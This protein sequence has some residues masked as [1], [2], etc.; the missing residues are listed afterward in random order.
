L[1]EADD[2]GEKAGGVPVDTDV[3][4]LGLGSLL[5]LGINGIVGVG[6]FFAPKELAA[7]APGWGSVAV[8]A[9]TG[10]ALLPVAL[11][12]SKLGSRFDQDG[13]PVLYAR[14]AFGDAAGFIVGWLA[15]VSA[16]FSAGTVMAGLTGALLPELGPIGLRFVATAL[17]TV[18]SLVCATGVKISARVWTTLTI[19]KLL[20]LIG[21]A[22]L[23][24]VRPAPGPSPPPFDASGV[25]WLRAALKATFVFQGF[26]I[27]PVIAGQAHGSRRNIPIAVV[28]SLLSATVIYLALVRGA[29]LGVPDLA[30]SGAPLVDTAQAY[31]GARLARLVALGTSV[32]GLGIAFGM[33]ATTPRYLSAL[34]PG[35]RFAGERRGVP[36]VA[37]VTTWA[38]VVVLVFAGS[39]GELLTLSSL[40]VV[41]QYLIVALALA[42]FAWRRERGL[43]P[44]AAW[45]AVPTAIVALLLLS[46][47]T[48]TEWAVAG[49]CAVVGVVLRVFYVRM[50]SPA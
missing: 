23:A 5:A 25:D 35:T 31:G 42:K 27:V 39:L 18:L 10:A 40:A 38:F 43:T 14:A 15:Y 26:E 7:L 8:L 6:I 50:K 13:G 30:H 2:T 4:P 36:L 22:V 47:A 44:A 16:L 46:G 21:L 33:V 24:L 11:A 20:P 1:P 17:V 48:G 34:A 3:R 49:A 19:L 29:V 32:S 9:V 41:M 45:S 12:V 28:A 37:L